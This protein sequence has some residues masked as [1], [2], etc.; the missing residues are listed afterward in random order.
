[1]EY[2]D[3]GAYMVAAY[4]VAAVVIA[5]YAVSLFYRIRKA[6]KR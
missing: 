4:I 6:A 5:V 1:M 2:P 3:N